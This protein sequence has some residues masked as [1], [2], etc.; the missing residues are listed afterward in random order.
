MTDLNLPRLAALAEAATPGPRT[1]RNEPFENGMPYFYIN[2][3][4]G[5]WGGAPD[6][7][8][9]QITAVMSQADAD[10]ASLKPETLTALCQ[11]VQAAEAELAATRRATDQWRQEVGTGLSDAT[12]LRQLR[13]AH[14]ATKADNARMRETLAAILDV[15]AETHPDGVKRER[16][17]TAL[18]RI[19]AIARK[20]VQD[21]TWEPMA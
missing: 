16:P 14:A 11:R 8:G 21:G 5:Y 15:T 17:Y 12:S 6:P 18:S 10:L 13:E 20:G 4:A 1:V 7:P 19:S 2:A 3:G 9:F